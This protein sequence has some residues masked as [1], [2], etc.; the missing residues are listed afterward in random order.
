MTQIFPP[1]TKILLS[2]FL[3]A[4]L[5]GCGADR[6]DKDATQSVTVSGDGN[7]VT[8]LSKGGENAD[9]IATTQTATVNGRTVS[10]TGCSSRNTIEVIDDRA[11]ING[12]QVFSHD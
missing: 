5:I 4:T 11:T 1:I 2:S 12:E 9:C 3:A 7:S 10:R 6:N 8:Q